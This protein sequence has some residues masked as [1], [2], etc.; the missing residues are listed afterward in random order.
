[1]GALDYLDLE[2]VD[3]RLDDLADILVSELVAWQDADLFDEHDQLL[4]RHAPVLPGVRLN[5]IED[6]LDPL[7]VEALRP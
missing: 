1:M 4:V 3:Q 2:V 6:H 5:S 7:Q